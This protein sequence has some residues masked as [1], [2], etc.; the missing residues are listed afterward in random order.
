MAERAAWS[1]VDS[2]PESKRF[3]LAAINP[4][5]VLGP[6]LS[7]NGCASADI[8]KKIILAQYPGLPSLHFGAVSVFDVARAHLLAMTK[9]NAAGKRFIL[10][11]VTSGMREFA[12]IINKVFKPL[13]YRPI[14]MHVPNFLVQVFSFFGDREAT[15]ISGALGR[16]DTYD[17]SNARNIL[18]LVFEEHVEVIVEQMARAAIAGGL[19]VDK[20]PGK[21]LSS[22]YVRPVFDTSMIPRAPNSDEFDL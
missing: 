5:V 18:G 13:G 12:S 1:F 8:I 2:L 15:A 14:T 19:I 9:E 3:E 10:S 21:V 11:P 20:S 4:A 17:N 7:S 16:R 22:E 6:M